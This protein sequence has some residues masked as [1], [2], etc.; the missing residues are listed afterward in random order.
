MKLHFSY[1]YSIIHIYFNNTYLFLFLFFFKILTF[2]LFFVLYFPSNFLK[3]NYSIRYGE[4]KN[5]LSNKDLYL[6]FFIF[7]HFTLYRYSIL[8]FILIR[9]RNLS[10][11][12]PL[13]PLEPGPKGTK[14][15]II[16]LKELLLFFLVLVYFLI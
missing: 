14:I 6:L 16:E 5:Y 3:I 9:T 2:L 11:T 1:C 8:Y 10:F 4:N 7:I 13:L 15:Y 12:R